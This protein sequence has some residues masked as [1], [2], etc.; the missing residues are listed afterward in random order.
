MIILIDPL[1][2]WIKV[3]GLPKRSSPR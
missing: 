2:F 3:V 1:L